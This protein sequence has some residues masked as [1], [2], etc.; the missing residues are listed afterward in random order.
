MSSYS[1]TTFKDIYD[2]VISRTR[3]STEVRPDEEAM[4]KGMINQAYVTLSAS[5]DWNWKKKTWDIVMSQPITSGTSNVS[6][7]S[8]IV[9]LTDV[10]VTK[11]LMGRSVRFNNEIEI[12]R[13]IGVNESG[14]KIYLSANFIGTTD[15]EATHQIYQ[16]EHT[17]PLDCDILGRPYHDSSNYN[18]SALSRMDDSDNDPLIKPIDESDFLREVAVN[19]KA[20]GKPIYYCECEWGAPVGLPK[21]EEMVLG[22]DFLADEDYKYKRVKFFPLDPGEDTLVHI[23]YFRSVQTL[24]ADDQ[25]PEFPKEHRWLIV[26]AALEIYF[27]Y[28]TDDDKTNYYGNRVRA[29]IN[30][31]FSK[32][33]K[34]RKSPR[35]VVNMRRLR[36]QNQSRQ[37][38]R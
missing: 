27:A 24:Y 29:F 10:T 11:E 7:G 16:H 30:K 36:R 34:S 20:K 37:Y 5:Y 31:T 25:Q 22:W 2:I 4:I 6:N 18:N 26:D 14:S 8:R 3:V 9:T 1:P 13:I 32:V 15:S 12:Y 35:L 33:N 17:L 23:P 21:L 28:E 19:S 38:V